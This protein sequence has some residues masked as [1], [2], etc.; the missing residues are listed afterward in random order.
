MA[1]VA[2]LPGPL[3]SK[4]SSSVSSKPSTTSIR[5]FLPHERC[6]WRSSTRWFAPQLS[7]DCAGQS[8]LG[9]RAGLVRG[10]LLRAFER[11]NGCLALFLVAMNQLDD[12]G[13]RV[14]AGI[15]EPTRGVIVASRVHG[16]DIDLP[17]DQRIRPA[18][19]RDA[20]PEPLQEALG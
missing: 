10:T 2:T 16:R 9:T 8:P 18:C 7:P 11:D 12:H 19:G 20:E 14:A 3:P 15:L 4:N 17:I 5:P 6:S 13:N 1:W